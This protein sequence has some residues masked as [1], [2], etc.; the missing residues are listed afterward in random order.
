MNNTRRR[1]K[2]RGRDHLPCEDVAIRKALSSLRV[3]FF[4]ASPTRHPGIIFLLFLLRR[5]MLGSSRQV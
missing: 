2:P 1:A 5:R 3:S 4:A